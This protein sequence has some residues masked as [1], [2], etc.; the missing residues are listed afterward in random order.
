[1]SSKR[2][3]RQSDAVLQD[4]RYAV[5]TLGRAPA[6]TAVALVTLAL[7]I[8]GTTAIFSV[9]DG[10]LLRPLPYPE[11]SAIIA[12]SR[13]RTGA[14]DGGSFSAAEFLDLQRDSRSFAALAGYRQEV[15]DLTGSVEPV[16]LRAVETT[17]AFFDVFGL[18]PLM[19]R[20]YSESTDAP[21]GPR[22]TVLS[23]G[24][25]RQ[26]LGG[27]PGVVGR[28]VRLNGVPFTVLGV[29]PAAHVHPDK[30]DLWMLAPRE[31]PTPPLAFDGDLLASRDMQYFNVIGRLAPD[32]TVSQ[33]RDELQRISERLASEF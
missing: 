9:V 8:G 22:V 20:V 10:I 21:G 5:R 19:G 4:V 29:M 31:V 1:V 23:E 15:V 24:M 18:P 27:D 11:P 33:A 13:V 26:H 32:A 17:A 25:W 16:R 28:T 14:P 30:A 7:G 2:A 3:S 12:L 6:F